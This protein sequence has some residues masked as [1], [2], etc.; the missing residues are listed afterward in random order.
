MVLL[1]HFKVVKEFTVLIY[2]SMSID[3]ATWQTRMGI[4]NS[5]KSL[6]KTEIKNRGMLHFLLRHFVC[7]L[8]LFLTFI[9]L[10]QV[11]NLYHGFSR[12]IKS[13]PASFGLRFHK[14]ADLTV[15]LLFFIQNV[16]SRCDDI[17]ENPG[18]KNS[19]LFFSYWNLNGVNSH[20]SS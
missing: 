15:F 20:D 10:T 16:Q 2:L 14:I 19:S 17:E 4:F 6:F 9:I 18:P 11:N 3:N 12:P 5:P 1:H 8:D 7:S 13:I